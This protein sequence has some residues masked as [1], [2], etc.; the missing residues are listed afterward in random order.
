M[1]N[2]IYTLTATKP[3][4]IDVVSR[5][6]D[7][8][9]NGVRASSKTYDANTETFD[10]L[11]VSHNDQIKAYLY[12]IDHADNISEPAV[13]EFIAFDTIAPK[14][15]K[16]FQYSLSEQTSVYMSTLKKN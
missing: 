10:S 6:L 16:D 1:V 13:L 2:L 8:Y 7:V 12:D 3:E 9:V 14:K 11:V 4:D 5:K 15:P